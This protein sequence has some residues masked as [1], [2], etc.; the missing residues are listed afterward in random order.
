MHVDDVDALRSA[1]DERGQGHVF[2]FFDA[3]DGAGRGRLLSSARRID[4]TALARVHAAS[5]A[6]KHPTA[7]T[8]TPWPIRRL[9]EHGGPSADLAQARDRGE[10]LL[11]NGQV[12][13]LVVA[14]GQGTRL[15]FDGPKGSFPIGPVSERSLFELQAQKVRGMA[16]RHGHALPWF[17][18]T[19]R[20]TDRATRA[21]FEKHDFFGLAEHD[22]LFFVQQEVPSL[23]FEGRLLLDAPD[24]IVESP[25]GHGGVVPALAASGAI[26][27]MDRRGITQLFYYQVDNPLVRIADP[28]YL[29]LH[30]AENAEMSCKV[31]P[32]RDPMDRVGHVACVDGRL[33]VVEYTEISD[34]DRDAR[35]ASGE[36]VY[37]AGSIAIHVFDVSFLRRCAADVDALLPW[38]ASAKKIPFLDDAGRLV[39]PGSPNGLKFERFVFDALPAARNA[40]VLETRRDEEY[41]PVKNASGSESPETARDALVSLYCRWLSVAGVAPPPAGARIEFD[42]ARFDG[43]DDLIA[44]GIRQFGDAGDAIRVAIGAHA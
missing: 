21:F 1:F 23:D 39:Q 15:G 27:E 40:L 38:H 11:R 3:L 35:T 2:R 34:R 6:L 33:G 42:H 19:S 8:L 17:V 14:G 24:H 43:P 25:C 7:R 12:G 31:I 26:D 4:L 36:L 9:P 30:V 5:E 13:V 18:M 20:A 10:T 32:K 41:E 22:V 28:V 37:W 16:R 44:S 29:G